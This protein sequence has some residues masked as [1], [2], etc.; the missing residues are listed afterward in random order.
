MMAVPQILY[1]FFS[2]PECYVSVSCLD[3]DDER[4]AWL[5]SQQRNGDK[6]DEV[7][8]HLLYACKSLK[9]KKIK[10]KTFPL[11]GAKVTKKQS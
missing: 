6:K 7:E 10:I 2:L 5:N 11:Y 3:V 8:K 4:R 1:F 9:K